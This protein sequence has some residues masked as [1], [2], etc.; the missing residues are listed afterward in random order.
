MLAMQIRVQISIQQP[1][2]QGVAQT[3]QLQIWQQC[4]HNSNNQK[5]MDAQNRFT[6]AVT[7][8]KQDFVRW[9]LYNVLKLVRWRLKTED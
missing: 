2:A 5:R 8:F 7:R 1:A 9:H 6:F 4:S 3:L